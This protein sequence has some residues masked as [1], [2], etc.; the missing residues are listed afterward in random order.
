MRRLLISAVVL[1]VPALFSAC[2]TTGAPRPNEGPQ[3]TVVGM[4]ALPSGV[5]SDACNGLGV[6]VT[7]A[8][9]IRVGD[10]SIHASR[11]R[12]SYTVNY[13]PANQPLKL[14]VSGGAGV[15][16]QGQVAAKDLPDSVQLQ[17]N[18]TKL[19]DFALTCGQ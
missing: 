15:C 1:S 10:S 9:G 7:N 5:S 3:G 17:A 11:N 16:S 6:A 8:N 18:E 14:A 12:C 4:M 2:A 19:V 13:V